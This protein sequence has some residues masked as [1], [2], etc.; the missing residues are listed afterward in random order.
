MRTLE[1]VLSKAVLCYYDL[2]HAY[3][4]TQ[5]L[6]KQ[7]GDD[8]DDQPYEHNAG[9]PYNFDRHDIKA[10]RKPWEIVSIML[11]DVHDSAPCFGHRN[12]PYCVKRI[13]RIKPIPWFRIDDKPIYAGTSLRQVLDLLQ[14][15]DIF[16]YPNYTIFKVYG[17]LQKE[18]KSHGLEPYFENNILT[19]GYDRSWNDSMQLHYNPPGMSLAITMDH[20]DKV[21]AVY[22]PDADG[23][24]CDEYLLADPQVVNHIVKRA[25]NWLGPVKKAR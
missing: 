15:S 18:L 7:W 16:H 2:S 19:M 17:Y 4:T 24:D 23:D 22:G 5:S 21:H 12:S 3:F 9:R 14:Q 10:K 8:W 11:P 20:Q 1:Q 25:I 6:D 13:N